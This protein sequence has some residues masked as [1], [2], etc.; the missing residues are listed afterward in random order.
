MLDSVMIFVKE[1]MFGKCARRLSLVQQYERYNIN[2]AEPGP[3]L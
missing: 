2:Q 1:A 3:T